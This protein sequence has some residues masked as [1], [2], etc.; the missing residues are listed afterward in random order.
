MAGYVDIHTHLLPGV[1]DGCDDVAESLELARRMVD[2]GIGDVF[3]TPH[4]QPPMPQNNRR[5]IARN[6]A[7]L[8]D[9]IDAANIPLRIHVGG[10]NRVGSEHL[11]L[12]DRD[13]V[14][15]AA[16][17]SRGGN[18]GN[19]FFLFDDWGHAR[20]RGLPRMVERLRDDGITPILAHPERTPW[21]WKKPIETANWLGGLGVRLQLNVHTLAGE[22]RGGVYVSKEMTTTAN[23]LLEA[24]A[25]DFLATDSHHVE[26]WP[27]RAAALEVARERMGDALFN[28]LFRENPRQVLPA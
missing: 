26:T 6:V 7:R 23:V 22:S 11:D 24:D 28:R 3:C 27:P 4:I 10:E 2:A 15:L 21:F 14:L 12:P 16:G 25:Y 1:D 17:D 5:Q 8:R 9:A 18:L 19:R 20:P 13:R